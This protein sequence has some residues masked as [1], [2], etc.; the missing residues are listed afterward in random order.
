MCDNCQDNLQEINSEELLEELQSNPNEIILPPIELPSEYFEESPE[1]QE[2]LRDGMKYAGFITALANTGISSVDV[3]GLLI[4][5]ETI[6]M[7]IKIAEIN[8]KAT[9]E[10]SKNQSIMIEKQQI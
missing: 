7:N 3:L 10:S 1:F 5:R 4:N 2:G 6:E 9:I 8:S